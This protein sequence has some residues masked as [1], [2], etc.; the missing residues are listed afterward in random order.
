M[1]MEK[2]GFELEVKTNK[3]KQEINDVRNLM[4]QFGGLVKFSIGVEEDVTQVSQI[5]EVFE[6]LKSNI[7]KLNAEAQQ[8]LAESMGLK[9]IQDVIGTLEAGF[10]RFR[11]LL[12]GDVEFDAEVFETVNNNLQ[13]MIS[14][15]KEFTE[16][17][18]DSGDEMYELVEAT[19]V[20]D[21]VV[22]QV[23]TSFKG[24]ASTVSKDIQ[25]GLSGAVKSVKRFSLSLFGIQSVYRLLSKASSQYLSQ[26]LETSNKLKSA[27]IGLGS[28][29]APILKKVADF[30]IT[31][32]KWL[33]I[34]WQA[35]TGKGFLA[36]AMEKQTKKAIG[37]VKTLNKALG[38]FDELT[39][40]GDTGTGGGGG[41]PDFDWA[42][43][44]KDVVI[45]QETIDKITAFGLEFKRIYDTYIKPTADALIKIIKY[46]VLEWDNGGKD[47]IGML[48]L[49]G[50]IFDILTGNWL[51][52]FIKFIGFIALYWNDLWNAVKIVVVGVWDFLVW[53]IKGAVNIIVGIV[54]GIWTAMKWVFDGIVSIFSGIGNFFK[55]VF[56]GAYNGIVKIFSGIGTFFKGVWNGIVSIFTTIGTTVGN[57]IGKAFNTVVNAIIGFAEKTINGFIKAINLAIGVI[58]A[59]PGVSIKKLT[60][61]NIPRLATGTGYVP[62][63]MQAIIHKGEAVIPKKFNA[64]EY[65]GAGNEE[66]IAEMIATREA[67]DRIEINPYTTIKDV[68]KASVNYI[69]TQKRV[70][71]V[72]VV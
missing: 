38:P 21:Q 72:E 1:A 68:G 18:D 58:N 49:I 14:N 13:H 61:L 8:D 10:V 28:I 41:T 71:G 23:E 60:L 34:F 20:A 56:T 6:N 42:D 55:N 40:I 63:D 47:I 66:L 2:F 31:A 52:L 36:K 3:A 24:V 4:K 33:D 45:P 44:F 69:N 70:L 67:I 15:I 51:G 27:W 29:F 39:N 26:D 5:N 35:F 62:Q 16:A 37:A 11:G 64:P 12:S 57:A 59:I 54:K 22:K 19:E 9:T 32:V 7:M 30:V 53:L 25:K 50:I 46:I 43:A 17:V 48:L 65:F